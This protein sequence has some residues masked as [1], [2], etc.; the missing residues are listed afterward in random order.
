MMNSAANDGRSGS[1]G[2]LGGSRG[3]REKRARAECLEELPR[4]GGGCN[5]ARRQG[6]GEPRRCA[7][8]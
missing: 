1:P 7:V 8:C 5:E 2:L 3:R 4:A 6:R